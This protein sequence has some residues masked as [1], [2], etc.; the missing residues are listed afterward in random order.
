M[1]RRDEPQQ[2]LSPRDQSV[3]YPLTNKRIGHWRWA[4]SGEE[5]MTAMVVTRAI[6]ENSPISPQL[7]RRY[8]SMLEKQR[9]LMA[10]GT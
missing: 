1:S 5:G 4:L 6:R 9:K 7:K 3:G 10:N 8:A 2:G